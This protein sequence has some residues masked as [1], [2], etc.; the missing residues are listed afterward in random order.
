MQPNYG[1]GAPAPMATPV[2]ASPPRT[3][4]SSI[5]A[6]A[7]LVL[8]V[9]A[10]V[11]A[12]VFPGPIGPMGPAGTNGATGATGATGPTGPA[13]AGTLMNYSQDDPWAVGG[14]PLVL[15][16]NVLVLNLTVPRAGTIIVTS[17]THLWIEHTA[18]TTDTWIAM[19]SQSS[20]DCTDSNMSLVAYDGNIPD[21][22]PSASL[23]NEVGSTANAFPVATAGAYTFY[24]N[25]RMSA[26][27]STGDRV[28]EASMVAVFYP[29]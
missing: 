20:T 13:G 6:I 8:A 10:L 29:G 27:E 24:L 9:V 5:L 28:S 25:V 16:T 15:C 19:T 2:P 1:G 22:W 14:L 3:G 11:V 7:A 21:S 26:G 4:M 23:V 18:G 17:T 12:G